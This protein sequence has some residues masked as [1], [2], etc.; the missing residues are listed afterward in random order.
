[1][2]NNAV[3]GLAYLPREDVT[4]VTAAAGSWVDGRR[5]ENAEADGVT[6]RAVVQPMPPKLLRILPEGQHAFGSKLLHTTQLLQTADEETETAA[7]VVRIPAVGGKRYRIFDSGD[8][9]VTGGFYRYLAV[10]L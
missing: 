4:V 7:D 5:V 1:M 2:S 3:A 6:F 8:W 10:L 9:T